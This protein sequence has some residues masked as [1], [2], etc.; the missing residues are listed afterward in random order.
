[1]VDFVQEILV[2]QR[3]ESL[4]QTRLQSFWRLVSYFDCSLQ[5]SQWEPAGWFARDVQSEVLMQISIRSKN[6]QKLLHEF[7][8]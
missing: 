6:V 1:M 7:N 2:D 3:I 5:Q 8:T 4:V